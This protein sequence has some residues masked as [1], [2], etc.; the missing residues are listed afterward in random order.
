[1]L[2]H[3]L[4]ALTLHRTVH[5]IT[6]PNRRLAP[7]QTLSR[8]TADNVG[9]P[10]APSSPYGCTAP[11]YVRV[12]PHRTTLSVHLPTRE[13]PDLKESIPSTEC[14]GGWVEHAAALHAQH[15]APSRR[16]SRAERQV[17]NVATVGSV[18]GWGIWEAKE[19]RRRVQRAQRQRD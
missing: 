6:R 1:V 11:S 9:L 18:W 19:A 12:R 17:E 5:P 13:R 10:I 4:R 7:A 15:P 8:P 2:R 16:V 14:H 3:V